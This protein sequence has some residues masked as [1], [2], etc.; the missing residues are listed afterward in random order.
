MIAIT[1][2]KASTSRKKK[3]PGARLSW[4]QPEKTLQV[5]SSGE[6]LSK[7]ESTEERAKTLKTLKSWLLDP[8]LLFMSL[9]SLG[10]TVSR[11]Q[12]CD[13]PVNSRP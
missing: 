7:E 6:G 12:F 3:A 4:R 13:P 5:N 8:G 1:T 2:T 10:S 11:N 9:G